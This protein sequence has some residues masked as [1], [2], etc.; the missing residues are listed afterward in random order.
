MSCPDHQERVEEGYKMIYTDQSL[1]SII[2][3]HNYTIEK[4]RSVSCGAA[5]GSSTSNLTGFIQAKYC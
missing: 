4:D 1:K 2:L 3:S 5:A